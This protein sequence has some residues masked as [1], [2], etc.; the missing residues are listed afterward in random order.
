MHNVSS[1]YQY[2]YLSLATSRRSDASTAARQTFAGEE[3]HR[4]EFPLQSGLHEAREASH[5]FW[6]ERRKIGLLKAALLI[7]RTFGRLG[8]RKKRKARAC[9]QRFG[10]SLA[11]I[12][13]YRAERL[14]G[15]WLYNWGA[16]SV[17][18]SPFQ[19]CPGLPPHCFSRRGF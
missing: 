12:S 18:P 15:L 7:I 8:A 5:G 13:F 4:W 10:G 17:G 1:G 19:S 14:W 11:L 2:F 3:R 16:S 9:G 6:G